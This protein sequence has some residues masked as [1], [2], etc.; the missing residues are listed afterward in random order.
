V[1]GEPC[2]SAEARSV[3]FLEVSAI[4]NH[5]YEVACASGEQGSFARRLPDGVGHC[6]WLQLSPFPPGGSKTADRSHADSFLTRLGAST[7]GLFQTL[8]NANLLGCLSGNFP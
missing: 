2:I 8:V 1:L 3:A 5:P 4:S 7:A 6:N